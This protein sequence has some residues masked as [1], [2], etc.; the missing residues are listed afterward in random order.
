VPD[1]F[2]FLLD[3]TLEGS[4]VAV[5]RRVNGHNM[6]YMSPAQHSLYQTDRPVLFESLKV[7]LPDGTERW[8]MDLGGDLS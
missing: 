5:L 6:I 3:H 4:K 2:N 8:I 1:A 7:S